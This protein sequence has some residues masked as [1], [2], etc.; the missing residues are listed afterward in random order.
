M[1]LDACFLI[2][3]QKEKRD[4]GVGKAH[5]FL[6]DHASERMAVSSVVAM[7]YLEGF[8]DNDL[9]SASQFLAAFDWFDVNKPVAIQASRLRR[10]LRKAGKLIPDADI[11]IAACALVHDEILVTDNTMHFKRIEGLRLLT[12]K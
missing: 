6:R 1:Q 7:E 11:L 5:Q 8:G 12:Y 9:R 2:D 10:N 3:L 4:E